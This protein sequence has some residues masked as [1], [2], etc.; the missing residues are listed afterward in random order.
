M[1]DFVICL[2]SLNIIL[3]FK[4]K[5]TRL[6]EHVARMAER[7]GACRVLVGLSEGR[8]PRRIPGVYERMI[9]KW[10]IKKSVGRT[11]TGLNW[12][13]I[14]TFLAIRGTTKFQRRTPLIGVS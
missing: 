3:V 11:W 6:A 9:L 10:I 1:R 8:R 7:R 14:G 2:S 12:L 13:R 4:Y 5:R